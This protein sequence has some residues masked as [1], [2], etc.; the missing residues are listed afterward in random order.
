MLSKTEQIYNA[1]RQQIINGNY[2]IGEKFPAGRDFAISHNIS[3]ITANN[4][5]KRLEDNGYL[6]RY[7]RRGSFVSIP[8]TAVKKSDKT[9]KAGYFVNINVSYFSRYFKELLNL[10][11]KHD[12]YNIPLDM[13]PTNILTRPDEYQQW[14]K[15][16]FSKHYNS[17]TVYAD[18]HFPFKEL[19]KYENSIEQLNF[20]FYDSSAVPFPDANYFIVDLEKVGYIAAKHLFDCGANKILMSTISNLSSSYRLQMGLKTEDHEFLIL[21]G[22]ERAFE[23]KNIDF[24]T[25]F[26][27]C[28]NAHATEADFIKFIRDEKF[29]GFF[30]L[31]DFHL[32]RIYY[33]AKALNMR[34]GKEIFCVETG[35]SSWNNIYAPPIS[36]ISFNETEIAK[37][38]A[39][40]IIEKWHGKHILVQ[41]ELVTRNNKK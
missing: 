32:E 36:S 27:A 15:N 20:I 5:L 38:T 34:F 39:A 26:K 14:L 30:S 19:K 4:V 25:N 7:P 8:G 37:L 21:K 17:I 12:I 10:T 2:S 23:E 9:F 31:S 33:A 13:T 11:S 22:I 24:W 29:N 16:I 6:R 35:N 1:V 28:E 41:P 40:A 18:R 3:Y